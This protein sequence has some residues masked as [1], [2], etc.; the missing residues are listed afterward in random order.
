VKDRRASGRAA[1][2]GFT[3]VEVLVAS[4]LL[5]VGVL[6]LL[7]LL[8]GGM[9]TTSENLRR[10]T[11]NAVAREVVE[12]AQSLR[13]DVLRNDL[14]D[15]SATAPR[16]PADRL[17]ASMDP[18]APA[19]RAPV[20]QG[21]STPIASATEPWRT[22]AEWRLTRGDTTFT[23]TYRACTRSAASN[24]VQ[25]LGP[26][27]C[28]R[29]ATTP[30]A[31][32]QTSGTCSLA[33]MNPNALQQVT[34]PDDV[35]A[36]VQL[37]NLLGVQACVT[38]TLGALN[39]SALVAPLCTV[40]G[41]AGYALNTVQGLLRGALGALGSDIALSVCPKP[42]GTAGPGFADDLASSTAVV[43]TVSWT[44][45]GASSPTRVV[46]RALIRRSGT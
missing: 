30:P 37:L 16:T 11:A 6:A 1:S 42:D 3:L 15:V 27:D 34:D 18:G 19:S 9:R 32:T 46:E 28:D 23:V 14:T 38:G 24:H 20:I 45:P 44:A 39:L 13:Y 2:A 21:T 4:T 35:V 26:Y 25:L 40:L 12:R 43:T 36:Q 10:D 8:E 29:T 31:G 41:D 7:P 17:W 5:L 22:T 33:L